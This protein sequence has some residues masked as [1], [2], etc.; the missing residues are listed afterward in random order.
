MGEIYN[1]RNLVLV[2]NVVV[3]SPSDL[4]TTVEI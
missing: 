4:S 3:E 2:S 1:S